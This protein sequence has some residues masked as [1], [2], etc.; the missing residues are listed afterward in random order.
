M[1]SVRS[2]Y[3]DTIISHILITRVEAGS[4][5]STAALRVVGGDKKGS[6][7]SGTVKYGRESDRAALARAS[8]NCK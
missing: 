1:W 8:S 6:I 5:T 7:E 2:L 3:N 4:N